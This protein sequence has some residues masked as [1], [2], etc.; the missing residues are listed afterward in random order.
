MDPIY[1]GQVLYDRADID[2]LPT[3]SIIAWGED[4]EEE[5]AVIRRGRFGDVDVH[6]TRTYWAT[7]SY[8]VDVPFRVVRLGKGKGEL[9][10]SSE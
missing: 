8:V 6:N 4:D 3:G 9:C 7:E 5:I 2:R 1:P 10:S